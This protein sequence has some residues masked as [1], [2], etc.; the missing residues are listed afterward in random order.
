MA[1]IKVTKS[2]TKKNGKSRGAAIKK[3]KKVPAKKKK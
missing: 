3:P 1:K 2:R